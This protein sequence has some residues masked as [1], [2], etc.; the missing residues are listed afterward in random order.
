MIMKYLLIFLL[1]LNFSIC[2][3][4]YNMSSG[5]PIYAFEKNV[6]YKNKVD[7]TF[8]FNK[9]SFSSILEYKLTYIGEIINN[10]NEH[11]KFLFVETYTGINKDSK[12]CKSTVVI[13]KDEVRYGEYYIGGKYENIPFIKEES[14][15]IIANTRKYNHICFNK[16]IPLEIFIVYDEKGDKVY[17]DIYTLERTTRR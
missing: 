3:E 6:L 10:Q 8:S 17:G 13:Y 16:E 12:R 5:D 9:T 14:V 7:T 15:V 2:L 1:S 11:L 4:C